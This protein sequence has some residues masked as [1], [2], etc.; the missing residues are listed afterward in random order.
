ARRKLA[1]IVLTDDA[2]GEN[3]L[4][5]SGVDAD[6]FELDGL[7]LYLR[8]GTIMDF[9]TKSQYEITVAVDDPTIS[10][11]PDATVPYVLL[12]SDVNEPPTDILLSSNR[13]TESTDTSGGPAF[14]GLLS[15]V[16]P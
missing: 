1:D 4:R 6:R 15:T 10:G 7:A 11:D 2:L 9:E 8:A 16:D 13:I 12:V 5:L 3:T 14:I